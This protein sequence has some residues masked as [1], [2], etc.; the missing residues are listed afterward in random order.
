MTEL[1]DDQKDCEF[2]VFMKNGERINIIVRMNVDDN[3]LDA[4]I[5]DLN[6]KQKSNP[7]LVVTR[8]TCNER[9][10][11]IININDISY[12]VPGKVHTKYRG[13]L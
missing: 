2:A 5:T 10:K 7:F 13:F 8:L 3:Q 11:N 6:N 12:I 4:L 1:K 9:V